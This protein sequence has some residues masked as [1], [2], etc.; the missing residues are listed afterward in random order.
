M[1]ARTAYEVP[2]Q[3][4][5]ADIMTR[6]SPFGH[7][8]LLG[9]DEPWNFQDGRQRV[10]AGDDAVRVVVHEV[11]SLALGHTTPAA[12]GTPPVI[13]LDQH[14]TTRRLAALDADIVF[15]EYVHAVSRRLVGRGS[16]LP[17]E[18]ATA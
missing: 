6:P 7:P 13:R 8:F 14:P 1:R 18:R 2:P 10:G 11:P 15:H 17:H 16:R 12:D 5:F 9:F 3:Q 4:G